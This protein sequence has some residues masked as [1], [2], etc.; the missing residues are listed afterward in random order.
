RWAATFDGDAGAVAALLGAGRTVHAL[1][2]KF[3]GADWR[4]RDSWRCNDRLPPHRQGLYDGLTPDPLETVFSPVSLAQA[5]GYPELRALYKHALW[6]AEGT[7][8]IKL[9]EFQ[10]TRAFIQPPVLELEWSVRGT[11]AHR[12][13]TAMGGD[14]CFDHDFYERTYPDM[15]AL[16]S[17]CMSKICS[18]SMFDHFMLVG[19]FQARRFK[20][21]C[22]PPALTRDQVMALA[23]Y[24]GRA[25][26]DA[27]AYRASWADL[28]WLASDRDVWAHWLQHGQFEGRKGPRRCP[29]TLYSP[30]RG[31]DGTSAADMLA[32]ARALLAE[33]VK[34][35]PS[36]WP[37]VRSERDVEGD[38]SKGKGKGRV[39]D[40]PEEDEKEAAEK[41]GARRD[42]GQAREKEGAG[43]EGREEGKGAEGEDQEGKAA[44]ADDQEG[45]AAEA[46]DQE[47]KAAEAEDQE[48]KA[49]K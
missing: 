40:E 45:K 18:F 12:W 17:S 14:A 37:G 25:C 7:G 35:E 48:G 33:F 43:T 41:E 49:A 10:G 4:D 29:D 28:G 39:D 21:T 8:D 23:V 16:R 34:P 6:A 20:F 36:L 1:L 47:G 32:E 30:A 24:Q 38:D 27:E 46:E 9:N 2:A 5:E 15:K 42:E 11:G 13:R 19:T 44:K 3:Q 26:F 22:P 31:P